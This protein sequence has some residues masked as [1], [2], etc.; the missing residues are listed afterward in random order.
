MVDGLQLLNS[1]V[2]WILENPHDKGVQQVHVAFGFRVSKDRIGRSR[3][4]L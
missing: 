1:G 2:L 4:L 3:Y